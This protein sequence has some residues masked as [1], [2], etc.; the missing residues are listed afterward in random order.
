MKCEL[1][2]RTIGLFIKTLVSSIEILN[3]WIYQ[4]ECKISNICKKTLVTVKYIVDCF[5]YF[6]PTKR[7]SA[8]RIFMSKLVKWF[9]NSRRLIFHE[10][11]SCTYESSKISIILVIS[12]KNNVIFTKFLKILL[13]ISLWRNMSF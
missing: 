4:F 7:I 2:I 12:F 3:E 9:T 1:H 10:E 6:C 11:F 8:G 5:R 13:L